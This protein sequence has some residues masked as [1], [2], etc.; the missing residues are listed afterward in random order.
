MEDAPAKPSLTR[1]LV[2]CLIF[3]VAAFLLFK[4]VVGFVTAILSTIAII[5]AIIGI[6]WAINV[7][8]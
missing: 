4:L 5:A 6:L 1:R 8:F 2:A 3:A 7:L